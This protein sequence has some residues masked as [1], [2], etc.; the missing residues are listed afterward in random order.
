MK[1]EPPV[2]SG[3]QADKA[4]LLD[5]QRKLYTWSR[6]HP[7]E[8]W[9]DMWGWLT[10]PRNLRVAW[11]RVARNRG[12]RSAGVDRLRS[13]SVLE[14]IVSSGIWESGCG[15]ASIFPPLCGA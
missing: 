1:E 8:P 15:L 4:W 11:R 13:S 14:S 9:Q 10:S 12:A 6:T 7:G 2:D 5:I 3:E